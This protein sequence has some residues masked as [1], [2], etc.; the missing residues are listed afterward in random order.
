MVR[1]DAAA[2]AASV[3]RAGQ[4]VPVLAPE[5]SGRD[6]VASLFRNR[7]KAAQLALRLGIQVLAGH[8]LNYH[9]VGRIVAID[10]IEELNIG[11]NIIARA[12]MVGLDRAVREMKALLARPAVSMM[13]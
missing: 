5:I 13:P 3:A 10:E 8:G 12:S 2:V 6:S 4:N 7:L 11:H 1:A 9:N